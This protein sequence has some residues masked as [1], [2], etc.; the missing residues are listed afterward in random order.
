MRHAQDTFDGHG[1]AGL[2]EL[3]VVRRKRERVHGRLK[4]VTTYTANA[5]VK[6]LPKSLALSVKGLKAGTHTV[7]VVVT[8]THPAVVKHHRRTVKLSR[9]LRTFP[10]LLSRIPA[11]RQRVH[12]RLRPAG[13]RQSAITG[14][15]LSSE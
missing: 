5:T 13:G 8:L 2:R 1:G 14:G 4:T 9:T 15:R 10:G 3:G 6:R 11:I 12:R 7:R